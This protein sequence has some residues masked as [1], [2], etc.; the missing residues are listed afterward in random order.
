MVSV[1]AGEEMV[2]LQSA[3]ARDWHG[4]GGKE[5]GKTHHGKDESMCPTI[6]NAQMSKTQHFFGQYFSKKV[7]K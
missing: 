1:P 3:A 6:W 4:G 5:L 2:V 7:L